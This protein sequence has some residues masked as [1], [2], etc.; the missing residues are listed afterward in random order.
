MSVTG[1][2]FGSFR[3]INN[4]YRPID[5]KTEVR[6]GAEQKQIY[7]RRPTGSQKSLQSK[8]FD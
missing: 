5:R 3:H 8:Y 1:Q 4:V 2:V 7:F 6:N